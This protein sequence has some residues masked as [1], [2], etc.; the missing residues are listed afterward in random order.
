VH[1]LRLSRSACGFGF[2]TM[3]AGAA[4]RH[5]G[6]ATVADSHFAMISQGWARKPHARVVEC[7]ECH[8]TTGW[9]DSVDVG[10][11]KHH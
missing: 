1:N 10:F 6:N 3:T 7:F 2:T 9:N 5:F 8:N 11:Y 4:T